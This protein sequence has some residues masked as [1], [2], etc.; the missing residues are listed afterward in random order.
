MTFYCHFEC[1]KA[2]SVK[3]F[4]IWSNLSLRR[5]VT[6]FDLPN[7]G[8]DNWLS[9]NKAPI[10]FSVSV[11]EFWISLLI[12]V[13]LYPNGHEKLNFNL[14]I[15]FLLHHGEIN[16]RYAKWFQ[17]VGPNLKMFRSFWAQKKFNNEILD[18]SW[19]FQ[20]S[21]SKLSQMIQFLTTFEPGKGWSHYL[22]HSILAMVFSYLEFTL[23]KQ[24]HKIKVKC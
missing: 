7:L 14:Q 12:Y 5:G 1:V 11:V 23:F 8:V 16:F 19:S 13:V 4:K 6:S 22:S 18:F 21:L 15:L 17:W 9:P 2:K 20:L 24:L 3:K 10:L